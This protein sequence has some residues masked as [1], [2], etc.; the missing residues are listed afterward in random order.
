MTWQIASI[1]PIWLLAVAGS[2]I[3][4]AFVHEEKHLEALPPLFAVCIVATFCVQLVIQRKEGFV[5]RVMASIA[6]AAVILGVATA[7]LLLG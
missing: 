4:G 6:G 3:V 2:V 7:V 1:V 5:N